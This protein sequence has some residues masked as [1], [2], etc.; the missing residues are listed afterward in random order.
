VSVNGWGVKALFIEPGSPW[1]NGHVGG[2]NGKLRDENLGAER[3]SFQVLPLDKSLC[4][5]SVNKT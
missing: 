3:C 5:L 4:N 1:E 2:L